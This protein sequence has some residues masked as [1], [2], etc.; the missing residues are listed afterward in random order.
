[1]CSGNCSHVPPPPKGP[2]A[3]L[4]RSLWCLLL[5]LVPESGRERG[6]VPGDR[7]QPLFSLS[8]LAEQPDTFTFLKPR[9]HTAKASPRVCCVSA[10][11]FPKAGS[12]GLCVSPLKHEESFLLLINST[13][14]L[15]VTL[16]ILALLRSGSAVD[17]RASFTSHHESR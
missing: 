13:R 1:M 4:W 9:K 2:S 8:F 11:F 16:G 7:A 6:R 10:F 3:S 14:R 12:V 15:E 5:S 17:I